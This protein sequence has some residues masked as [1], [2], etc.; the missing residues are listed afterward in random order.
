[1]TASLNPSE[2]RSAARITRQNLS[3]MKANADIKPNAVAFLKKLANST[4]SESVGFMAELAKVVTYKPNA[5][6]IDGHVLHAVELNVKPR[7][8]ECGLEVSSIQEL[9]AGV[10]HMAPENDAKSI[11]YWLD[12]SLKQRRICLISKR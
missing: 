6:K 11:E 10:V 4:A 5:C 8:V 3:A 2:G 9:R 7:C 12:P 1:M